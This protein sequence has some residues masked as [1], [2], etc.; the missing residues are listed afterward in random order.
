VG[1]G[2]PSALWSKKTEPECVSRTPLK[3]KIGCVSGEG[4][5][6]YNRLKIIVKSYF[7]SI[8]FGV[9]ALLILLGIQLT[10]FD[11]TPYHSFINNPVLTGKIFFV[12]SL[13][14]SGFYFVTKNK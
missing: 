5:E 4:L 9:S 14:I 13:V 6:T 8:Y 1:C 11:D 12:L 7:K 10:Y 2:W 3:Q